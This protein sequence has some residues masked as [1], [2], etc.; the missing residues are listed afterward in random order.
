MVPLTIRQCS[1][2][3]QS[4]TFRLGGAKAISGGEISIEGMG[5]LEVRELDILNTLGY[6]NFG[7]DMLD[8]LGDVPLWWRG[9]F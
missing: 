2:R 9:E 1:E 7:S 5:Q 6:G 3:G 4:L 8:L